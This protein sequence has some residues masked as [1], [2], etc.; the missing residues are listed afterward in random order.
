MHP[1]SKR[2]V[3]VVAAGIIAVVSLVAGLIL[4]VNAEDGFSG[5][6]GAAEFGWLAPLL[7]ASIIGGLAW[8]LLAQDPPAADDAGNTQ[9]AECP[10][11]KRAVLGQWRMCPYCGEM[12]DPRYSTRAAASQ[13]K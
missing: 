8:V 9:I 10:E 3:V 13:N 1:Q 7:A 6:T 12:L 2:R 5:C 11:C 4:L